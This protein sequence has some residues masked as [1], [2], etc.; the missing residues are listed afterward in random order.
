MKIDEPIIELKRNAYYK[1]FN[2]AHFGGIIVVILG[3]ISPIA[4]KVYLSYLIGQSTKV[5]VH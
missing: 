2:Y 5:Q 4:F 1:Y 3:L